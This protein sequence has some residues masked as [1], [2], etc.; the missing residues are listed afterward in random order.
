[1]EAH[2]N[3]TH[4][5][6]QQSPRRLSSL[7]SDERRRAAISSRVRVLRAAALA[8][9]TVGCSPQRPNGANGATPSSSST[10]ATVASASAV[11]GV[12]DAAM[13]S[14]RRATTHGLG[15]VA[16]EPTFEEMASVLFADR[17]GPSTVL[18]ECPSSIESEARVRCLFDARY[19]GDPAAAGLAHELFVRWRVVAGV[20]V[21]HTMDGGYRGMIRIE[22]AVPVAAERKH[23]EWIVGAM[24]EFDAFF[25]DLERRAVPPSV[26][27][28]GAPALRSTPK[29]YRFRP[30]TLR[31][32]RSVAART[33]S[34]YAQ[35]WTVAWNL[36]GSL[37]TS[38][39]AA[40]ETLFHEIFHLNDHDAAHVPHGGAEAWSQRAL[41]ATFEAIVAQCKTS[42]RCFA[43]F[44]PSETIV[45]GGTYYAFQ[46]GNGVVEYAAELALRY[47]RE[48]RAALRV[49]ARASS[50]SRDPRGIDTKPFKCG[51]PENARAWALMRDEFFRGLDAVPP[52][53]Q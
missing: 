47:F 40:R 20:E 36:A 46:P 2:P 25:T 51:P 37:H 31:F 43:P 34:A 6:A 11:T 5:V 41:G 9:A 33:P 45:R 21:A 53:G 18:A 28:A 27:D 52:C 49:G 14:E 15:E 19:R 23:L 32:M 16:R 29:G 4:P 17:A 38:A 39:D 42:T 26:D 44:A 22:P 35:G 30:I 10:L 13:S 24:S 3:Q 8:V 12:G 48:Q 1:M 7:S 50:T